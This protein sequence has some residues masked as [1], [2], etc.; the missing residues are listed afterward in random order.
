MYID[1]Q[2][3][4]RGLLLIFAKDD[5][6]LQAA[7]VAALPQPEAHQVRLLRDWLKGEK[8]GDNFLR[9]K[10]LKTWSTEHD[11]EFVTF[12]PSTSWVNPHLIEFFHWLR[13]PGSWKRMKLVS[14]DSE[15]GRV[16]NSESTHMGRTMKILW[17][18]A[19]TLF[20]SL[21]PVLAILVLYFVKHTL[22]RIAITIAFTAFFGVVLIVFTS[23]ELEEVFGATAA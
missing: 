12:L 16:Y 15:L 9:L 18:F 22:Y 17:T 4:S 3:K 21:L 19:I 5:E 7:A 14:S 2:P 6:L 20:A 10:E 11:P 23:A 1:A 13:H 8:E